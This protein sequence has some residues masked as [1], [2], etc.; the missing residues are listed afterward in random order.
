MTM[1]KHNEDKII[2]EIKAHIDGTYGQ[3]Y[4]GN[5]EIQ[6]IDY[7]ESL[8]S[9]ETTARDNIIKYVARF[10]KKGGK[11]RKDLLKAAHYLVL[12]LYITE[13]EGDNN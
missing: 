11:N 2:E 5:K 12:M 10:G 7:W 3:H 8:G 6:V 4:V 13:K 1:Y 9:L